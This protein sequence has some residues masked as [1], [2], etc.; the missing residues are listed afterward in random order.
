MGF[1]P[2]FSGLVVLINQVSILR[3]LLQREEE[4]IRRCAKWLEEHGSNESIVLPSQT[5]FPKASQEKPLSS[6]VS[7]R[8]VLSMSNESPHEVAAVFVPLAQ[9]EK[10]FPNALFNC[11]PPNLSVPSP[12]F[13]VP[14]RHCLAKLSSAPAPSVDFP[15]PNFAS[16]PP[17]MTIPPPSMALPPPHMAVPPP[18]MAVPPAHM[19][20]PPPNMAVPPAHMAVP[21]PNMAV[22]PPNIA[23]PPPSIAIPPPS[24]AI[25]P[26][27]MAVPPPDIAVLPPEIIFSPSDVGTP[28]LG[29]SRL[30]GSP[31]P[32]VLDAFAP[33]DR[34]YE[35]RQYLLP[36]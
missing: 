5:S 23:V 15:P 1:M 33:R 29:L 32:E 21:P 26:P 9:R 18:S 28:P 31:A 19:A 22:P 3:E 25:P 13:D 2:C 24:M 20:V 4:E 27:S 34:N 36:S 30:G 8:R 17:N 10:L 35:S 16:L 7:S 12:L 11:L 6:E 14:S